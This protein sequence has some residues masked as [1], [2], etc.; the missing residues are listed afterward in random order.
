M[1]IWEEKTGSNGFGGKDRREPRRDQRNG[2]HELLTKLGAWTKKLV[3][4]AR[5]KK[6]KAA[7]DKKSSG[8]GEEKTAGLKGG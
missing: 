5:L 2:N 4:R 3:V 7:K 8:G 6:E 1:K